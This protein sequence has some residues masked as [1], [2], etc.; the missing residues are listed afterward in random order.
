MVMR[1]RR[2]VFAA[3]PDEKLFRAQLVAELG[4]DRASE[5][6]MTIGLAEI[7]FESMDGIALAYASTVCL[8]MGGILHYPRNWK[9]PGWTATK[10]RDM[11]RWAKLKVW[12]GIT[13]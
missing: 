1:E 12:L 5:L 7:S 2:F 9:L 13:R 4:S 11:S 8:G 6:D 3:P 10:W